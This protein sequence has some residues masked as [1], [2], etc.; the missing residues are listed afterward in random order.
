MAVAMSDGHVLESAL[1][2]GLAQ[3]RRHAATLLRHVAWLL[4]ADDRQDVAQAMA[5]AVW[6][7]LALGVPL[8]R[9]VY[10]EV[11]A[12]LRAMGFHVVAGRWV[13]EGWS[14]DGRGKVRPG[15]TTFNI[16]EKD[17]HVAE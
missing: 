8:R 2:A 4:T 14:V 13:R 15:E 1:D 6:E 10:R 12:T 11:Y 7:H 17:G 3:A 9:A 16:Y 5:L